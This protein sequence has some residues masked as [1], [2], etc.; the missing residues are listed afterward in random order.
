DHVR[1]RCSPSQGKNSLKKYPYSDGRTF[2]FTPI[3]LA[4]KRR[5]MR[6]FMATKRLVRKNKVFLP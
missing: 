1:K 6:L 5:R 3:R 4:I 2:V